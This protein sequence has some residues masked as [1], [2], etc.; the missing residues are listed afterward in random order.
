MTL[1]GKGRIA[2]GLLRA[3]V[4][5]AGLA[6]LAL[7]VLAGPAD[8]A[9]GTTV[10]T[11]ATTARCTWV[12]EPLPGL[13]ESADGHVAG[14]D[15]RDRY[16]GSVGMRAVVWDHR[17]PTDLG[18]G[19]ATDVNRDG[20]V[21]G[22]IHDEVWGYHAAFWRGTQM[23]RLAEPAGV[24][25]THALGITDD[26]LIVGTGGTDQM[27]VQ[28]G[29]VWSVDTPN[30]VR[31][32]TSQRGT[33]ELAGVSPSGLIIGTDSSM[34]D[35]HAVAVAGTVRTGLQ[36]LAVPTPSAD[37]RAWAADGRYVVGNGPGGAVIWVNGRLRVLPA[38]PSGLGGSAT[39]VNRAGLAAGTDSISAPVVWQRGGVKTLPITQSYGAVGAVTERGEVAGSDG[40]RP[41]TWSC[42]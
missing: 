14:T 33:L 36:P 5:A 32:I 34:P 18:S 35:W 26:G 17:R 10:G 28:V 6:V 29:L 16:A 13:P 12:E 9:V 2:R 24:S 1:S 7:P 31:V 23:V 40:Y 22:A 8:A 15:G 39:A 3:E 27:F 19:T 20:I 11:T 42:R 25:G 37:Y 38:P 4:V 30:R 41:V 21:V